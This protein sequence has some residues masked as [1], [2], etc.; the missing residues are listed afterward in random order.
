MPTEFLS[1]IS[2]S[3]TSD[4][5]FRFFL[6]NKQPPYAKEKKMI[7][8][9]P[10]FFFT[11]SVV[12]FE[13][14]W[15]GLK[16]PTIMMPIW[17]QANLEEK[18][19]ELDA[20]KGCKNKTHFCMCGLFMP[21]GR[22][23]SWG[24]SVNYA[25]Y[26]MCCGDHLCGCCKTDPQMA[27]LPPTVTNVS[28]ECDYKP[29]DCSDKATVCVL[30]H[31]DITPRHG[32]LEYSCCKDAAHYTPTC[33]AI[34]RKMLKS[35]YPQ[36]RSDF[37]DGATL[38]DKCISN[39]TRFDIAR[40]TSPRNVPSTS[41]PTD[42][43]ASTKSKVN[44][45][46]MPPSATYAIVVALVLGRFVLFLPMICG[47]F[48]ALHI[49]LC[50]PSEKNKQLYKPK[51][52]FQSFL[53]LCLTSVLCLADAFN[54]EGIYPF[55]ALPLEKA[56]V[57]RATCS[58]EAQ[59][60]DCAQK[61]A[62]CAREFNPQKVLSRTPCCAKGYNLE[63][64]AKL[65]TAV[66]WKP[67]RLHD[68]VKELDEREECKN[69]EAYC[70]CDAYMFDNVLR[71]SGMCCGN[72]TCNCCE[73]D[74][75]IAALAALKHI[76]YQPHPGCDDDGICTLSEGKPASKCCNE[77]YELNSKLIYGQ[78]KINRE[79]V[80][81]C[82]PNGHMTYYSRDFAVTRE[83]AT[84]GCANKTVWGLFAQKMNPSSTPSKAIGIA[85]PPSATYAIVVA[86]VLG[87]FVLF[88]PMICGL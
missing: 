32:A 48:P 54:F 59:C 51:E 68:A 17:E 15:S 62:I 71:S 28:N 13:L 27:K 83:H 82:G 60:T 42:P 1:S 72:G 3:I 5:L 35:S 63:C 29:Y 21:S 45:V 65:A 37:V 87:H 39:N 46:A 9:R 74:P 84:R 67:M 70:M 2:T 57:E 88:L 47:L 36:N 6:K 50:P 79:N 16:K 7:S 23:V 12:S 38:L 81:E 55:P 30:Q 86:L 78:L 31:N 33:K 24:N 26:G 40:M 64:C 14:V 66:S 4:S 52:M 18:I 75:S 77:H 19:Q 22:L 49:S 34:F 56:V 61:T 11:L 73:T 41:P 69:E 10:L 58:I 25:I 44:G 85:M 20:T 76:V 53:V 43:S 80:N 8:R